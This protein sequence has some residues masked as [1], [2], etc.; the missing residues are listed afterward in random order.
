MRR[1][2]EAQD[3]GT[4]GDAMS[5]GLYANDRLPFQRR[6]FD[7]IVR[8]GTK[9]SGQRSANVRGHQQIAEAL[10]MYADMAVAFWSPAMAAQSQ[11]IGLL[12]APKKRE[13]PTALQVVE[14]V[15]KVPEMIRAMSKEK[16]ADK[17][18]P[19]LARDVVQKTLNG[20]SLERET[21]D[22]GPY[23]AAYRT[24]IGA[25]GRSAKA[26]TPTPGPEPVE[27]G[28]PEAVPE[29]VSPTVDRNARLPGKISGAKP[30]F[31]YREGQFQLAFESDID[32]A[33]LVV[34]QKKKS[35]KDTAF[36]EFLRKAGFTDA[37]MDAEAGQVRDRIRDV[38]A[39]AVRSGRKIRNADRRNRT[40]AGRNAVDGQGRPLPGRRH[41][42]DAH[43]PLGRDD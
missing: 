40:H 19:I 33:L 6:F 27:P 5:P 9:A 38:G 22:P 36:R 41:P 39:S 14:A 16:I 15:S 34:G 3:E 31:G 30:R 7:M 37:R 43:R 24:A 1:I 4:L 18:K 35:K 42:P 25:M 11:S 2:L 8:M 29:S 17:R 12:T 10:G 13:I 26:T 28:V 21:A 32:R 20:T 23:G